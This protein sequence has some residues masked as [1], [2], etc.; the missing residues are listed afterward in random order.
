MFKTKREILVK[1]KEYIPVIKGSKILKG[2]EYGGC[3]LVY[4]LYSIVDY[5]IQILNKFFTIKSNEK[6][7]S[8]I[9]FLRPLKERWDKKSHRLAPYLWGKKT[10]PLTNVWCQ[11][12]GDSKYI[13]TK[14]EMFVIENIYK[15]HIIRKLLNEKTPII[16]KNQISIKY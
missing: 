9:Y 16:E 5:K 11:I 8:E 2:S 12:K 10:K 14:P 6:F 4:K 7:K 13:G 3:I 1:D 15:N